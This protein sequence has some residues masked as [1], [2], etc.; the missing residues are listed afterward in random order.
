MWLAKIKNK[1]WKGNARCQ[2]AKTFLKEKTNIW[3]HFFK[4]SHPPHVSPICLKYLC[5]SFPFWSYTKVFQIKPT[6]FISSLTHI[7]HGYEPTL[8]LVYFI[9][10]HKILSYH[11]NF[12]KWREESSQRIETFFSQ[13]AHLTHTLKNSNS[14]SFQKTQR[15]WKLAFLLPFLILLLLITKLNKSIS[16][17][18]F[19]YK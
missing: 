9:Y 13:W 2:D 11:P 16:T 7:L 5:N 18:S 3:P 17:P 1:K 14:F 12:Q 8:F 6:H 19:T 4:E 15:L 10:E